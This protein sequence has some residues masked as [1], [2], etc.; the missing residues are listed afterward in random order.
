MACADCEA[1]RQ[2]MLKW[3][4]ESLDRAKQILGFA[5][6]PAP[7]EPAATDADAAGPDA[8][9]DSAGPVS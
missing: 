6:A 7:A 8:G 3:G 1:R 9:D 4:K 2:W 5:D